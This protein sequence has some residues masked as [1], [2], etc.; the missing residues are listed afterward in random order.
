MTNIWSNILWLLDV[1]KDDNMELG[2]SH[3]FVFLIVFAIRYF[4]VKSTNW[5]PTIGY[6]KAMIFIYY[7]FMKKSKAEI[8]I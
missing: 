4:A 5:N 6:K 8:I 1:M 3:S 7:F 2:N